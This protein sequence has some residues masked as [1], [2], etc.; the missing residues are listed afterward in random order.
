MP[1]INLEEVEQLATIEPRPAQ[2]DLS[3]A[4]LQ[5]DRIRQAARVLTWRQSSSIA[6]HP[7]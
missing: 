5:R 2:A 6:C 7:P 3:L 4:R 1:F